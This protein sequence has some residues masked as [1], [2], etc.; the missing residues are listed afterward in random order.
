MT[1]PPP[2]VCQRI[3]KLHA[4]MGSPGKDADVARQKLIELLAEHGLSWND[5]TR[6]L[7]A[8]EPDNV[9]NHDGNSGTGVATPGASG[10]PDIFPV[11]LRL[12]EEHVAATP[13]EHLAI[14]LWILHTWIFDRFS[15]TPRLYA[16]VARPS[17]SS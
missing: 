2:K 3:K 5:L 13:D 7:A 15:V 14:A 12:V 11:L 6:I 10:E 8:I 4:L 17:C 9:A 16:A 1:L